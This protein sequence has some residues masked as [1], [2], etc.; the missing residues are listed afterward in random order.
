M[1][2]VGVIISTY[3]NPQWLEK[4]LWGYQFQ[5]READE[6]IIADDGSGKETAELIEKYKK[7]LPIKHVW[8]EDNGFRKT[9]ILNQAVLVSESEYLI[10]ADQ[11]CIPRNDFIEAHVRNAQKG[12][13]LSGGCFRLPMSISLDINKED[14]DSQQIFNI[15]ELKKRGLKTGWKNTKLLHSVSFAS[16]MNFITPTK[17]TWNGGNS[18]I[19]KNDIVA[20]NGFNEN[21]RY[22]GEDREFGER[23]FNFGIKSKQIR[24]S[25]ICLHLDHA[26]P[27]KDFKLIE[28]NRQIRRDVRKN[29]TIQALHG[30]YSIP[31]IVE[32]NDE[33]QSY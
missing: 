16:F 6:I 5:L 15:S 28:Q 3:N 25:A 20:V 7:T 14:V 33:K 22:G 32:Q 18:S 17:A 12:Y 23:L 4:T 11:D 8:H 27:Y 29:K 30:I 19:W 21:M 24:Y 2:S 10:F 1:K 13:M 31:L 9:R 26:R